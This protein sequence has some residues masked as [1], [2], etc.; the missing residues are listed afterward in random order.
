MAMLTGGLGMMAAARGG[1]TD[2]SKG[3]LGY[4]L[5][6]GLQGGAQ[7]YQ[8]LKDFRRRMQHSK[9]PNRKSVPWMTC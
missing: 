3:G 6:Q 4:G 2:L 5:M 9:K 7:G 8:M 1:N